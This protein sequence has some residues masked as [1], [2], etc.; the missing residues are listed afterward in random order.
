MLEDYHA[1][2]ADEEAMAQIESGKEK[3]LSWEE[4]KADI[5]HCK[6]IFK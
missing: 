3:P 1:T 6:N 5:D 4:V 2:K